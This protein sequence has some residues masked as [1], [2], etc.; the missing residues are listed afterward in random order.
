MGRQRQSSDGSATILWIA[1]RAGEVER[2]EPLCKKH[3]NYVFEQYPTSAHGQG[4]RGD[5]CSMCRPQPPR[6][7]QLLSP[8]DFTTASGRAETAERPGHGTK[9]LGRRVSPTFRLYRIT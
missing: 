4:R 6:T 2:H 8:R 1:W 9:D 5:R 7:A 3:R